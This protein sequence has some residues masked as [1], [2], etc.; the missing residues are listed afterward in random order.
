M[1]NIVN[2]ALVLSILFLIITMLQDELIFNEK[3]QYENKRIY[4]LGVNPTEYDEFYY[5]DDY[6]E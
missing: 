2:L 4:P 5:D 1:R 6:D 3:L